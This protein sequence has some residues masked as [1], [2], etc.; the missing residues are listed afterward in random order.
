MQPNIFA[1]Y[2]QQKQADKIYGI[3]N[4]STVNKMFMITFF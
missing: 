3:E 4:Q 2:I 1:T